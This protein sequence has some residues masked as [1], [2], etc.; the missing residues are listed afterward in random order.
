MEIDGLND[1]ADYGLVVIGRNASEMSRPS[2]ML[3]F[4]PSAVESGMTLLTTSDNAIEEWFDLSGKRVTKENLHP[5]IYIIRKGT[6]AKRV[7]IK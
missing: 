3:R 5:G 6:E 2:E 1:D 7:I 4:I